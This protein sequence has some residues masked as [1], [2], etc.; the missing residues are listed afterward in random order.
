MRILVV[1]NGHGEDSMAA[2]VVR[3]LPDHIHADAY[4]TLGVGHA[5][6]GVCPIVGPRAHIASEGDRTVGGSFGSDLRGGILASFWP[7]M[8]FMRG[9][10]RTYDKIV[11]VGDLLGVLMCWLARLRVAIWVDVFRNGFAHRYTAPERWLIARTCGIVFNRDDILARDLRE[12]GIDAR[13]AG[14]ILMDTVTR[15]RFEP[16]R[17]RSRELA[18]LLL[19]GSRSE[20]A[21][22]FA[23]QVAAIRLLPDAL[24]PDLFV[25]L[26]PGIDPAALARASS[27]HW[28][29]SKPDRPDDLGT[30]EGQGLTFHLARGSLANLLEN[31]DCALSLAGTATWQALG[32]GVPVISAAAP[33]KRAKRLADESRL[34]GGSRQVCA[35]DP[36]VLAAAL[37][38]LLADADER[39]RRGRLGRER[40]GSP[41]AIAAIVAALG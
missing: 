18:V 14:N 6:D 36:Q 4:P 31:V 16:R 8:R 10:A 7:A 22:Q 2:E 20:A 39:E 5:F 23:L 24:R 30:L 1:S 35:H 38:G 13:A 9:Q 26:A 34:T 17:Y 3:A 33:G 41:G 19:P 12:A 21:E 25:G 11:V 32:M 27:L 15:G 40:M 37:G 29:P 28:H